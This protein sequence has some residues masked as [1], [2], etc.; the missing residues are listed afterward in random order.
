MSFKHYIYYQVIEE[1]G[2]MDIIKERSYS[3]S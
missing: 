3:E 1:K 2:D